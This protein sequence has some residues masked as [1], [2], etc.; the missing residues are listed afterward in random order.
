MISAAGIKFLTSTKETAKIS[1]HDGT[2]TGVN[3]TVI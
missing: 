3:K 1:S 2:C